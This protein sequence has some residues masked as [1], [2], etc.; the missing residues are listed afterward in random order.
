MSESANVNLQSIQTLKTNLGMSQER[1]HMI[2]NQI[3]NTID[4]YFNSF[5][6]K[7]DILL[8]RLHKA[9]NA[10]ASAENE[11][12]EMGL[13]K[14]WVEDE[15]GYGGH[16]SPDT[17][18]QETKVRSCRIHRDGC[19]DKLTRCRTIIS[20]CEHSRKFIDGSYRIIDR[21]YYMSL[22]DLQI[23]IDNVLNYQGMSNQVNNYPTPSE[24]Q[25]PKSDMKEPRPK[26][27]EKVIRH[28]F[29]DNNGEVMAN[30]SIKVEDHQQFFGFKSVTHNTDENGY[31]TMPY[32]IS[33]DCSIYLD[34]KEIYRGKLFNN[35]EYNK[36]YDGKM[37]TN[38]TDNNSSETESRSFDSIDHN[39]DV[40]HSINIDTQYPDNIRRQETFTRCNENGE[41]EKI[42]I[43][44]TSDEHKSFAKGG[45]VKILNEK[46]DKND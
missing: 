26:Y 10:L 25:A 18:A 35:M 4:G 44:K 36:Y 30:V 43:S 37:V 42:E 14:H 8:D 31:F 24:A 12:Y 6:Q 11:L 13:R 22:K 21:S 45:W 28:R 32:A 23:D 40:T 16:W 38:L 20:Q 34:G 29:F 46:E 2:K 7:E 9:E 33:D 3:D 15:D 41:L 17:T 39:I 27:K 19:R 1:F 5:R